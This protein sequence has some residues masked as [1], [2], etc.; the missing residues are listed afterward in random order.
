MNIKPSSDPWK[1]VWKHLCLA[2]YS[3]ISF[4]QITKEKLGTHF[5]RVDQAKGFHHCNTQ[6]KILRT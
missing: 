2:I 1:H 5:V 3:F 4:I 6:P